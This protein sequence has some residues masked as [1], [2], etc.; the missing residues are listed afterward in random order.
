[1]TSIMEIRQLRYF[2][3]VAERMHFTR[4]A[5]FLHISQPA[6]SQQ[7]RMLEQE[8]GV[9]LLERTNRRV[10]LT[11]AGMAF[12][13]RAQAALEEAAEAAS[14]ARMVER[15]EWGSISIGFVT[16]AA[17]VLL[18]KL[19]DQFCSQF[20]CAMVELRELDPGAQ[21][22]ALEQKRIAVGFTS[23][24]GDLPSLECRLLARDELIVA[25]PDRHPIARH[26]AIDLKD[27]SEERFLIP[28]R[29]LTPGIHEEILTACHRA[30]FVPKYSQPIK[31]AE[32]AVCL[33]AGNL[34]IALI[35]KSFR[36]LKVS[37]VVYRPL[38]HETLVID[39]YAIKRKNPESPLVD[40]FWSFVE[41]MSQ[42]D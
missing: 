32:T 30:G 12:R 25:L 22:E 17:V 14:D 3:A 33:V 34:G 42:K 21:L 4:A 39:L 27:L 5:E 2:L 36:R 35:P 40:N 8:I 18:P 1:M 6:L 41:A 13:V 16:T 15:G 24:P 29:R 19:L 26:R 7:I 11:P 20:P 23:V 31:L 28:P 10:Q 37:G 38:K 9:K